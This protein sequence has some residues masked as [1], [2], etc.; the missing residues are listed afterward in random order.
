MNWHLTA[1]QACPACSLRLPACYDALHCSTKLHTRH[2]PAVVMKSEGACAHA[3]QVRLAMNV[4]SDFCQ[5]EMY[6]LNCMAWSL[7]PAGRYCCLISRCLVQAAYFACHATK[8]TAAQLLIGCQMAGTH[9]SSEAFASQL[10]LHVLQFSFT[11][12]L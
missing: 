8:L 4:G 1:S 3:T 11:Q 12:N 5:A 9:Q 2:A 10:L 6:V 7:V